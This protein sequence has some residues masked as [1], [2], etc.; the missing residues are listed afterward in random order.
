MFNFQSQ[1]LLFQSKYNLQL[2]ASL[3]HC[4]VGALFHSNQANQI[5][6]LNTK[7]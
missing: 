7:I 5:D 2:K 1:Y 6:L 3:L 4:L